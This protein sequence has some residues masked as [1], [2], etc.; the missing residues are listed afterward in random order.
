MTYKVAAGA[1]MPI[2]INMPVNGQCVGSFESYDDRDDLAVIVTDNLGRY[3][4]TQPKGDIEIMILDIFQF[5]F[6]QRNGSYIAAY[7]SGRSFGGTFNAELPAG[8]YW[9]VINNRYSM[10]ARKS[11]TFTL[12]EPKRPAP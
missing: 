2:Y 1:Y 6:F 7:T 11:V 4:R 9:I 12:G 3:I 10:L 8:P 5:T